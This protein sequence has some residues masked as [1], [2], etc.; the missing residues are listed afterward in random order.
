[1]MMAATY[2]TMQ[3]LRDSLGIGTLYSDATV[4]ECAQTAQDLINAFL[5]FNTAPIV[6]TGRS[7][8]VATCII[9]NPAQFVVGQLITITGSGSGY[10]GV[11]T[12]TSTSPY[13]SS[14]SAPYLP[15][16]WVYPLGYQYIQFANVAADDPIHLVQPYGLMAGP[17]DKTATYAQTP[18]IRSAAMILA[19]NIWQSRQ[20][21]QNG[22]MGVD[23]YAPSPFRMSN[24]LMASIRGLLAPYLSPAG[25]VG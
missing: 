7:A 8:N 21:T 24:T 23:G 12:I 18:A 10:N 13:P 5:W 6:A 22:G 19:T 20:A 9:A 17:D 2:V 16:R 15:S 4:E 25:M 1:M 14:V 11:K 3:E